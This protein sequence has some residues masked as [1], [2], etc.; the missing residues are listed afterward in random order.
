MELV[1]I[2]GRVI[3]E[4]FGGWLVDGTKVGTGKGRQGKGGEEGHFWLRWR[5]LR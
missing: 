5:W 4:W 2:E 3:V 1:G